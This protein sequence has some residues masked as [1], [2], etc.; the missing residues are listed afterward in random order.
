MKAPKTLSEIL[1]ERKK[2]YQTEVGKAFDTV[3]KHQDL[4]YVEK[5]ERAVATLCQNVKEKGLEGIT[6]NSAA[7]ETP[8]KKG[9]KQELTMELYTQ[10]KDQGLTNEQIREAYTLTKKYQLNGCASIY[11]QR[12][13][14]ASKSEQ[15]KT[16]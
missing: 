13:L 14:N 9:K 4:A 3:Y 5:F 6:Q 16:E 1:G 2:F 10:A 12:K 8:K 7:T 15:P 11:A